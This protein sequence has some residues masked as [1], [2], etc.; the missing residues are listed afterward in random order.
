MTFITATRPILRAARSGFRD[1]HITL[2]RSL[3]PK[4]TVLFANETRAGIG[5]AAARGVDGIKQNGSPPTTE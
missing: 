5:S 1:A 3:I 4:I 2:I